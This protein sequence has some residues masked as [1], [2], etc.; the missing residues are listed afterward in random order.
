M[1]EKEESEFN[2]E[3]VVPRMMG[4]YQDNF[5]LND[6]QVCQECN[7]FF[8]RKL[9]NTIGLDSLEGLLRMQHGSRVMTDG[10]ELQGKRISFSL[11]EGFF[12]GLRFTVVANQ[13]NKERINIAFVPC[14]GILNE[15]SGYDYYALDQLPFATQDVLTR[16]K[17]EQKG[18]VTIELKREEV[19]QVL[20]E[21][22]YLSNNYKYKEKP[23]TD[24]HGKP[25][26]NTEIK[27]SIDTIVRRVCAKTVFN[28]LCYTEGKEFVLQPQFDVIRNY[29]RY[30]TWADSLWFRYSQGPVST[31]E[32]PNDT[33][34]SIG[35][36]WF[37][38]G[39]KWILCGCL[40]WFGQLTYIFKLGTTDRRV[41]TIN[42][43]PCT[44]MASFDNVNQN[45]KEDESV[46]IYEGRQQS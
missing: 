42:L 4:T 9:E 13:S 35:Y 18:I 43:L 12:K 8:D 24:I 45:I 6:Y 5:V 17:K 7:S 39:G 33:S 22:G 27:F 14:I 34:H 26:F 10:R 2:R 21:K 31:A 15:S 38:E 19:E 44:K 16:L 37:S 1:E 25:Y 28:Y 20:K 32:L 30:G 29:I 3:H 11:K 23:V 41:S 36:M 46:F 40:T